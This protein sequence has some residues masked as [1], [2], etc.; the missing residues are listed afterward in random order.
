[1]LVLSF[2]DLMKLVS[3][4]ARLNKLQ[5]H[6]GSAQSCGAQP[7]TSEVHVAVDVL[8]LCPCAGGHCL[9]MKGQCGAPAD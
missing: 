5:M 2:V 8:M 7:V 3:Q 9:V 4:E 6:G 1:M